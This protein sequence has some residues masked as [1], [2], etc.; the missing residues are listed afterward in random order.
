MIGQKKVPIKGKVIRYEKGD[1]LPL[2]LPNGNVIAPD[3][4]YYNVK[5]IV[6]TKKDWD[7]A[8]MYFKVAMDLGWRAEEAFTAG[9]NKSE[10]KNETGIKI[11]KN[12]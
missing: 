10:S 8:F 1:K 2:I 4:E 3:Q 11:E 5:K 6:T 9:A 7:S 12:A